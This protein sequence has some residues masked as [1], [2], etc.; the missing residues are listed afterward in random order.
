[1][2]ASRLEWQCQCGLVRARWSLRRPLCCSPPGCTP[3]RYTPA[4]LH[5]ARGTTRAPRAAPV[6]TQ[7][8]AVG[9]KRKE[10]AAMSCLLILLCVLAVAPPLVT[11]VFPTTGNVLGGEMVEIGVANFKPAKSYNCN[12]D[13]ITVV[14][15][16]RE[17]SHS[18]SHTRC[19]SGSHPSISFCCCVS[20]CKL[21]LR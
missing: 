11:A 14:S 8:I 5:P 12:F 9:S 10:F 4:Q 18:C 19:S 2:C 7:Y 21:R 16:Q 13:R 6:C 3:V 1:M 17:D 20:D 15:Q